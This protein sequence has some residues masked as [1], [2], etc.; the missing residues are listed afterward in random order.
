MHKE[1]TA[2]ITLT[3][4]LNNSQTL[5]TILS[6]SKQEFINDEE[7]VSIAI[8]FINELSK[9]A[10]NIPVDFYVL[11][12]DLSY[13]II[14]IKNYSKALFNKYTLVNTYRLYDFFKIEIY[15]LNNFL[16]TINM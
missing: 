7:L 6:K 3:N 10:S 15:N 14:A 9:I 12:R 16:N 2:L 5:Q 13:F 8:G 4:T 1:Y 11:N